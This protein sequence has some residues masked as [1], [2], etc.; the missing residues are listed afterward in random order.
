MPRLTYAALVGAVL[1]FT[2]FVSLMFV[3]TESR[4]ATVRV[5]ATPAGLPAAIEPLAPY[6]EQVS[7]DP[8]LRSGAVNLARL[9]ATTYRSYNATS[10]ASPYACGTDGNRSEHYD[11]RAIDWM[12]SVRNA[13]QYAAAKAALGWLLASDRAGHQAAMARRLGVMYLIYNNRMWGSW[14]G[15]WHDYNNCAHRTS[16]ADDNACHRTHVHISLS[17][18]GATGHTSFWTKRVA[19]TDFGRCRSADLNWA[20]LYGRPNPVPCR[21]YPLVVAKSSASLTKKAL[22]KYSGAAVRWGWRGPAVTAVQRALHVSQT[23]V[24]YAATQAAVRL[25]QSRHHLVVTGCMNT[26]TWRALLA[27]ER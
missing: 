27:A 11:G 14:D 1:A 9:L 17:W 13:Q 16:R 25:F 21:S 4:A 6:V 22:V 5:P 24:Y 8:R 2:V 19:A 7:C 26:P 15:R 23:G 20:Y 10:W 3:A 12:V 18:N